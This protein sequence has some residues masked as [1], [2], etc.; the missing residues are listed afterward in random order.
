MDE[1]K[2]ALIC[3][4][5]S[6]L[7][8]EH[9]YERASLD[10]IATRA[11]VSKLTIYRHFGGKEGLFAAVLKAKCDELMGDIPELSGSDVDAQA[12]L[13]AAGYAFVTLV[14]DP[15]PLAAHR[16]VAAEHH[17][18][19]GL[20]Q[21]YFDNTIAVTSRRIARLVD[22]LRDRGELTVSDPHQ[23]ARDLMSLWRAMPVL[24]AELGIDP[25]QAPA[26]RRHVE[27]TTHLLMRAWSNPSA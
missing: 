24:H 10:A 7:F 9:G 21:L 1:S 2:G 23:A 25:L 11:G 19:P 22:A 8:M 5:A 27:R 18:V 6:A 26:L 17:R 15:G 12:A 4:A 13:V 14:T 16:L 20:S 3:A